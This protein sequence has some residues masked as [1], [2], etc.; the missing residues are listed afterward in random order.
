MFSLIPKQVQNIETVFQFERYK[1]EIHVQISE[2][3]I[4]TPDPQSETEF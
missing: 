3:S 4:W 1:Q 2:D